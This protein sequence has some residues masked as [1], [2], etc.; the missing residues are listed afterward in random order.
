MQERKELGAYYT[1]H[2]LADLLASTLLSLLNIDEERVYTVVDPATGDSSL[3]SAFEKFARM[4]NVKANY[5]GIDVEKCAV[6]NSMSAFSK[7]KV[8]SKFLNTDALYPLDEN[9]NSIG[10]RKLKQK[11][12][13]NGIDFIVS[14]P[15]WGADKSKYK[16]LSSDFLTAKGQFDIYDLFIETSIN[17]LNENGCYAIIV[18]DSIYGLEH[19][20]I[21]KFLFQN[22]TIKKIIRIGEGFFENVSIAVTLLFGI[23][24]QALDY[25]IECFHLPEEIKKQILTHKLELS[26]A[27]RQFVNVVPVRLMLDSNFSFLTDVSSVD[28]ELL[29]K[30]RLCSKIGEVTDSQRGVELSKK[31]VVIKCKKCGKWFPEPKMINAIKCPHCKKQLEVDDVVIRKI[32]SKE[33]RHNAKKFITGDTIFRYNTVAKQFIEMGYNGIN[34]KNEQLYEGSKILVRKT[35]VGIT[36]GIDYDNCLTNQ[37]VYILKRKVNLDSVITNE[38]ILAVLNSRVITYFIIVSHGS[39]GWKTHAYLSQSD[40]AALPFPKIDTSNEEI[41]SQLKKITEFVKQYSCE[42]TDDFPQDV[43]LKI[44]RIIA[45]LFGLTE[46]QY[47]VIFDTIKNVQQMIPFKRLLKINSKDTFDNGL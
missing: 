23:K 18:P 15:P 32:V 34:Y 11:Y 39:N 41:R 24:R 33:L 8:Q 26:T 1:P 27:V 17:N 13:P 42:K 16:K 46:V 28:V 21:R 19:T 20:P 6:D 45:D 29:S 9:E 3:L 36:A 31:G 5:V 37:V 25:N 2:S 10:W 4:M 14:N 35:G 30:L 38:V 47:N 40:V 22:T 43:D 12:L 7:K 44:E